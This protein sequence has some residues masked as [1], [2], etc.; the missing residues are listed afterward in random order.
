MIFSKIFKVLLL[1][2]FIAGSLLAAEKGFL[3][4][5]TGDSKADIYLDSEKIGRET[6]KKHPL[7]EGVHYLQIKKNGVVV[8]AQKVNIFSGK[9]ETIVKDDFVE[10]KT[11]TASSGAIEAEAMRVRETRGNFAMGLHGGSPASGLSLK[12]MFAR[13]FGLQ[14][15]GFLNNFSGNQDTRSAF[16]FIWNVKDSV[17]KGSVT[18]YYFALGAGRSL[19]EN[20]VDEY[21]NETYDITDLAFGIEFKLANFFAD[22]SNDSQHIVIDNDT[23]A[24]E[25]LLT[26][27]VIGIGE[28]FMKF[29]HLNFEL[30]VE[31]VF[32]RY[33]YDESDKASDS[34]IAAKV[35]GGFHFYF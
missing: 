25:A 18:S 35:S 12:W 17:Y 34:K 14:T 7:D 23:D 19:L 11:N 9:T 32:T 13:N 1:V 5:F 33:Y 27:L 24:G 3:N 2:F 15:I 22:D 4:V 26:M 30:G 29:A 28:A 21:K 16:R 6:V 8:A 20:S 31:R 10:Y